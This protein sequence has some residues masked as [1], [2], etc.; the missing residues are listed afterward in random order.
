MSANRKGSLW[1]AGLTASLKDATKLAIFGGLNQN[2][3]VDLRD[4]R[5]VIEAWRV[6]YN[7]VR[8]Q[9]SQPGKTGSSAHF[10]EVVSQQ[11][12]GLKISCLVAARVVIA[13]Y[14]E[15]DTTSR[16]FFALSKS[17]ARASVQVA[18]QDGPSD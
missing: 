16:V 14:A 2:W 18:S 13:R 7:T 3:F 5:E 17:K 8:P 6:D 1:L 12:A 15:W 9:S 4:A 10:L 11:E